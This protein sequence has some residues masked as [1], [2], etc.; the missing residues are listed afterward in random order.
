MKFIRRTKSN[1]ARISM[2]NLIDVIF[3]LLLFFMLTATFNK[4]VQ[5]DIK[6]PQTAAQM[7]SNEIM[8]VELFYN[9]DGD[10]ML[11][12]GDMEQN[13]S[14]LNLGDFI[15]NLSK[16]HRKTIKLN[17]DERLEYGK[18]IDL[19]SILKSSDVD[20]VELNIRKK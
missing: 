5:F 11:R 15:S 9:L 1:V 16:E 3:V 10:V 6:L 2:L 4:F 19:I 17:A 20:N 7:D 13:L 18:I 8:P 14:L 12:V